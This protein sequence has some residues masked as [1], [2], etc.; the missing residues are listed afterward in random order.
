MLAG[1]GFGEVYSLRGG[2][3]AWQGLTAVGPPG[4]GLGL[5]RGDEGL[6]QMLV[7]AYG[8]EMGLGR[9]YHEAA[10]KAPQG[11]TRELLAELAGLE[12]RHQARVWAL[13]AGQA[14]PPL[15]QT[16]LAAQATDRVLEDGQEVTRALENLA[17]AGLTPAEVLEMAMSLETQALDLYLRLARKASRE[18]AR[19]AL[20][21]L[22]QE[23]KA[24]L[25]ALGRR[26]ETAG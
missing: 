18:E 2:I 25:T 15:D 3:K 7:V 26:L 9:F 13:Y 20:V 16:A 10:A 24:H 4:Q 8:M 11:P 12:E 21:Q 22:A 1:A 5:I 6:E 17:P 14:N 19:G 23:E